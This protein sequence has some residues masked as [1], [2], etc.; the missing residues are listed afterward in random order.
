MAKYFLFFI[1]NIFYY[2]LLYSR[3]FGADKTEHNVY[4]KI[5][6]I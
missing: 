4:V 1:Q 5:K 2:R 6:G 3:H